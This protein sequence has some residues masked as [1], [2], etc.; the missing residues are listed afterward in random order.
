MSEYFLTD[1]FLLQGKV[2]QR[3]YHDH[4]RH[5]PI[6]DY[7]CHLAPDEIASNKQFN[8]LTDIWLRGDHYKWRAQ[9]SLG[10]PEKMI[11]GDAGDEE[12]FHAW[13]KVVPQTV[14]IAYNEVHS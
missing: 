2:A 3:L 7:H 5:L 13:A 6:I 1:D 8:N 4:V 11:T 9:R 12:K 10:V 14:R